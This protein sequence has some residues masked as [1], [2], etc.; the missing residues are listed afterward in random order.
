MTTEEKIVEIIA[1]VF[2]MEV[3]RVKRLSG[4]E[5]LSQIGLDSINC[6]EVVVNLEEEFSI[7]FNDEELLLENLN[8]I[9]KLL[10]LVTQKQ[11][12]IS[13]I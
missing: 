6:M 1:M 12:E 5:P 2:R 9:Q 13:V 4:E 8:T 7:T 3:D 11:A 10:Q